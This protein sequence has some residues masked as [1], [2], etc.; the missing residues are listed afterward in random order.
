MLLQRHL[1]LVS[2]KLEIR[3]GVAVGHN[4]V[5]ST[6]AFFSH[7]HVHVHIHICAFIALIYIMANRLQRVV[8]GV[9]H[10]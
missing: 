2:A 9:I 1:C 8:G 7:I 4:R 3:D 10:L 5:Y 6:N